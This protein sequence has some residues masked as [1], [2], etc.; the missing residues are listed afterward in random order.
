MRIR[1]KWGS[2]S[3]YS[4]V[5]CGEPAKDWAYD[6][7]D[8]AQLYARHRDSGGKM[9]YSLYPEFYMPMCRSCHNTRDRT[10]SFAELEEY[11]TLKHETGLSYG[12]IRALLDKALEGTRE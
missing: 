3:L 11:R 2:A 9:F 1:S 7:T 12:E 8:D 4:C 5:E 6:G 10:Q